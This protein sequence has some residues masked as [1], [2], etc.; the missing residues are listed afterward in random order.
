MN[1]IL[2]TGLM[3]CMLSMLL[4]STCFAFEKVQMNDTLGAGAINSAYNDFFTGTQ[5]ES[6]KTDNFRHMGPRDEYE[7]YFGTVSGNNAIEYIC[8]KAGYVDAIAIT[9]P[10][11]KTNSLEA[12]ALLVIVSNK[13]NLK[14]A[15]NQ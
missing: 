3:V 6:L 14:A 5:C 15:Q 2:K 7:I 8:N 13:Y 9:S 1:K 10:S 4:G 11:T 12:Y